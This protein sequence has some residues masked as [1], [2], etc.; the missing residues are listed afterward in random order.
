M[1][2]KYQILETIY[3]DKCYE[4]TKITMER[5]QINAR[6]VRPAVA[7]QTKSEPQKLKK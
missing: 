5:Q 4:L 6:I 7:C 3:S 1:E 2:G